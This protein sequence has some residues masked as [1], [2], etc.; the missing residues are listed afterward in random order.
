MDKEVPKFEKESKNTVT[1]KKKGEKFQ[2]VK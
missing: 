1:S 2:L